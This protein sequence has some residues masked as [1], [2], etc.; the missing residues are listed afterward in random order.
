MNRVT[1][2]LLLV[3]GFPMYFQDVLSSREDTFV[4]KTFWDIGILPYPTTDK[5]NGQHYHRFTPGEYYA[6][7][8]P[9]WSHKAERGMHE[10]IGV[11]HLAV[12]EH[13]FSPGQVTNVHAK[14]VHAMKCN[15]HPAAHSP[16]GLCRSTNCSSGY[17]IATTYPK[18]NDRTQVTYD[19][20]SMIEFIFSSPSY[21]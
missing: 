1:L 5:H 14:T 6:N 9:R 15:M 10:I 16:L 7:V 12:K 19:N 4:A 8:V 2:Q 17:L 21:R 3:E 18:G 13:C 20:A 11:N